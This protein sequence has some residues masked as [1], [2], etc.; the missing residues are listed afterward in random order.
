MNRLVL[1][2]FT[3]SVALF[4]AAQTSKTEWKETIYAADGFA[5]TSPEPSHPHEDGQ[6]PDTTTYSLDI[7]EEHQIVTLRVMHRPRNCADTLKELKDKS[8][9]PENH[10]DATSLKDLVIDGHPGL[11]YLEST[12]SMTQFSRYYCVNSQIYVFSAAWPI[13]SHLSASI[14]RIMNSFRLVKADSH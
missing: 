3:V 1:C 11:E 8:S 4:A 2:L 14:A 6:F 5:L 9:M 10:V 7:R 12:A 13:K